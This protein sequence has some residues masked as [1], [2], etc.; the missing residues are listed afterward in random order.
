M[1]GDSTFDIL[2]RIGEESPKSIIE[3]NETY[4]AWYERLVQYLMAPA[5]AERPQTAE[6]VT[7]LLRAALAHARSPHHVDLPRE[8][9]PPNRS[10]L[11]AR[12]SKTVLGGLVLGALMLAGVW[13]AGGPTAIRWLQT[14]LPQPAAESVSAITSVNSSAS[15]T[16]STTVAPWTSEVLE[17]LLI[18]S[19]HELDELNHELSGEWHW[20][21][22]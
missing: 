10:R 20:P 15:S 22:Q 21:S 3:I 8:L 11:S 17:R 1:R 16:P 19:E 14:N 12:P 13:L 4:P 18:T 6:Q 7:E 9:L 2:R 5:V